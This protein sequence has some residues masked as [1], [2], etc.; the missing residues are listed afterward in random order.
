M[1]VYLVVMLTN[2]CNQYVFGA[3]ARE[4]RACAAVERCEK[5]D[6]VWQYEA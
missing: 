4:N 5:F 1:Y 3:Y 2:E 6:Q